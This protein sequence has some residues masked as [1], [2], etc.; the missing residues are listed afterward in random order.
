MPRIKP[1]ADVRL[2][3]VFARIGVPPK[4]RFKPDPFQE[5]AVAMIGRSDCLV[6]A[7]TGSGKT[8][9][10]QEAIQR[11][12]GKGSRA[13]YASPLKALTNAKLLEFGKV[14]GP[15]NVGILTGDRKENTDAPI[16]V[17]TTEILRNQLYDAMHEGVDLKA[18]LVVLDEAHFLGDEDRGVVWEETMIYLPSRVHLLLLS[19]TIGNARQIADW[20]ETIRSKPC[21]V[22]EERKRPVPLFPLFFHPTGKLMPLRDSKGMDKKVRKYVMSPRPPVLA[23]PRDLPPF[24][25]ILRVLRKYDLLPAVFFMKSRADCDA[26][27]DRCLAP[28]GKGAGSAA[29]NQR[30]DEL[31]KGLV[32][33]SEHRQMWPLRNAAVAAHHGGQ[34]P[35]WK[36]VVELLMSEG[37]LE[38][39]FATS[40][41]AAGVDFPAR[42]VV[43]LN[44][45]RYNGQRF[46]PLDSTQF[47]QTTGRAGRRGKDRIG[48]AVVIP[49]KYMDVSLMASLFTTPPEDV[50]SRIKID[51]PMVLNLLLSHTPVQIREIFEKSF[52]TYLNLVDQQPG[53]EKRLK[54]A[55]R[56]VK[57]FLPDALCAGPDSVIDLIRKRKTLILDVADVNRHLKVLESR[58][59]KAASL[60][61]GRLFL[62]HRGRLQCAV[63]L[64]E[65]RGEPGV[66]GYRV[67]P[68]VPR[69]GHYLR[70]RW[71][72]LAKISAILDRVVVLPQESDPDKTRGVLAEA[73]QGGAPQALKNL[74]LGEAELSKLRPLRTRSV[75]LEQQLNDIICNN[76]NQL[77]A[78]HGKAKGSFR[79]ALEDFTMRWDGVNAVRMRLWNDFVRHL[80]FLK[81]EGFVTAENKLTHDGMWASKLRLDQP[82]MIAEGLRAGVFPGSDPALLAALVAPFVHDRD[83]EDS[84]EASRVP[85]DLSR[86]FKRLKRAL[87]PLVERKTVRGFEVRPIAL[88]PSETLYAWATGLSWEHVLKTTGVLEGDLSMLVLRT[89]ENLRQ[90]ASLTDEY[91]AI[92][93]NARE[94]IDMIMREPVVMPDH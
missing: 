28:L 86:A 20:L 13:W 22:V 55:S 81:G 3:K 90:I 52:A 87:T 61:P 82:L 72:R 93:K 88:R 4:K 7:P 91:P 29:L 65:K 25:S 50:L 51:F 5:E 24:G 31:T 92:A 1:G 56:R 64:K 18:D 59:S 85:K 89:A 27:L 49:G 54:A 60:V 79:R 58:L 35:A 17:G 8:W 34:L 47:H 44:S 16:I 36:L 68:R 67:K 84:S 57:T 77:R 75:F 40:T 38:T 9:I 11:V 39:V 45:D 66:L 78:C 76:C 48:F 83:V 6:S 37:L 33:L 42:S 21:Q 71:F 80:E 19:A 32:H 94:A 46:V 2:K 73:V 63:K 53:F 15:E 10:A 62:D 70:T 23:S 12:H 43:F 69:R 26:A 30:I 74:P 14:F 41:V